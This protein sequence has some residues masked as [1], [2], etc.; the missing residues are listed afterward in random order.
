MLAV[1]PDPG[2]RAPDDE[3]YGDGL[4]LKFKFL[5]DQ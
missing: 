5:V 1:T 4:S 2:P 3:P